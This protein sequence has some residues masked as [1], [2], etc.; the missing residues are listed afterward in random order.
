MTDF[1]TFV[2][3]LVASF[4]DSGHNIENMVTVDGFT[5]KAECERVLKGFKTQM[6]R[7]GGIVTFAEC[8]PDLS[9]E[10]SA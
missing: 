6:Q 4:V 5:T 7:S 2:L 9:R 8:K 1:S 10:F 3:I